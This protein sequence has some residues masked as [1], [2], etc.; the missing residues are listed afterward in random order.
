MSKTLYYGQPIS[1][2]PLNRGLVGRWK[3]VPWYFGGPRLINLAGKDHGTLTAGTAWRA[4]GEYGQLFF[5]GSD[6]YVDMPSVSVPA[7]FTLSVLVA[8]DSASSFPMVAT[9]GASTY[10]LA[11]LA[12]TQQPY[13]LVNGGVVL[14]PDPLNLSDRNLLTVVVTSTTAELYVN[15]VSK[16]FENI[17]GSGGSVAW[18]LEYLGCRVP[19]SFHLPGKIEDVLIW[20]RAL[21]PHEVAKLSQDQL[22]GSPETLNWISTRAYGFDT[23]AAPAATYHNLMLLGVGG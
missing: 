1:A 7:D 21:T 17:S 22:R 5:D 12:S 18:S 19:G 9:N 2:N 8:L 3:V 6:D 13:M 4:G 16:D 10:E 15:G 23:G 11:F 20:N 14:S